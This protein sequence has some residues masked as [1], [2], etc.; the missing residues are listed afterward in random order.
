MPRD[1]MRAPILLPAR[2]IVFGAE[3]PLFAPAHGIHAVGRNAKRNKIIL[4][5]L[6]SAF[7]E[8]NIIFGGTTLVA[9]A[10]DG[11]SDLRI[12]PQKFSGLSQISAGVGA[13]VG[14]VEVKIR[15]LHILFE[16]L[17]QA[18]IS[19]R[20]SFHWRRTHGDACVRR[21]GAAGSC[22]SDCEGRRLRR[23]HWRGALCYYFAYARLDIKIGG[24]GRSPTQRDRVAALHGRRRSVQRNS[25][26]RGRLR[27][28][29][30]RRMAGNRL[31]AAAGESYE[32]Y[33]PQQQSQLCKTTI[34]HLLPPSASL[35]GPGR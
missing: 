30:S 8:A 33:H 15:V 29:L 1:E 20:R 21:G 25:G 17:A 6:G 27:R 28:S 19:A 34:L 32:S 31:F 4:G 9:M 18:L 10:L 11:Y 7:A 13:N 24:V 3:W 14:F 23:V 35:P 22:R 5:S 2:F 12:R 16:Q 26:L